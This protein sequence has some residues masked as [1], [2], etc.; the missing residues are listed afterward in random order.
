M[1]LFQ[2]PDLCHILRIQLSNQLHKET[3]KHITVALKFK[4]KKFYTAK[5]DS[6]NSLMLIFQA[7]LVMPFQNI[8]E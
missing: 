6:K 8:K 1:H 5:A 7:Y 4:G 3:V 2:Q